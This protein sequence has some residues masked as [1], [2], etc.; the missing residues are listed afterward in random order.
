MPVEKPS[1]GVLQDVH[2]SVGLIGYF[3]T[4]S[5]GNVYAGCLYDALLAD[6]PD[7]ADH[8]AR[9]E[10]APATDW[11][12]EKLQQHGG[13]RSPKDTI[14]HATGSPPSVEP[15]LSY[16]EAKFTDLYGL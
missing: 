6:V 9:G 11:L 3:P 13:L 12:K 16:L 14:I 7:L 15:L 4:Y 1:N 8:L 10:T 5:S 2:W